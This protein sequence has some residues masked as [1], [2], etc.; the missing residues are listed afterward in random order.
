MLL[1]DWRAFL[2]YLRPPAAPC[3]QEIARLREIKRALA[4]LPGEQIFRVK[5]TFG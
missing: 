5:K 3:W 2:F 4:V 1:A